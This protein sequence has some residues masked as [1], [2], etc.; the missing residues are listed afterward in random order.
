M[1]NARFVPL[2]TSILLLTLGFFGLAQAQ[3]LPVQ[4]PIRVPDG[5]QGMQPSLVRA[6][7]PNS[8]NG[9]LG[10]GWRLVGLS[11][12]TRVDGHGINF[13]GTDTYAHS[14]FG[15]LVRALVSLPSLC[16]EAHVARA[17]PGS[18]RADLW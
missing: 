14:D 2:L 3:G 6:Y 18:R 17:R 11:A 10:M 8:G 13:D 16:F 1:K 9:I 15:A 5:A 12:I 4:I 7:A